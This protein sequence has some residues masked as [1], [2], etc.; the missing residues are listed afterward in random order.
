MRTLREDGR[1]AVKVKTSLVQGEKF[2]S[3]SYFLF[4]ILKTLQ[5]MKIGKKS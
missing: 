3:M 2:L 5:I 4:S 1:V